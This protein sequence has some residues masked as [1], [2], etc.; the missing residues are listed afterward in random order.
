[1]WPAPADKA[2]ELGDEVW[3][4]AD[5]LLLGA[6]TGLI[7][8]ATSAT[9]RGLAALRQ[10]AGPSQEQLLAAAVAFRRARTLDSGQDL[11]AWLAARELTMEDWEAHLRRSLAA[12]EL[13]RGEYVTAPG[14]FEGE[15][16]ALAVDLACGGWWKRFADLA[17]RLWA[18]T[19]LL[20]DDLALTDVEVVDSE[21]RAEATR[22]MAEFGELASLGE[23]W[24][25]DR[26]RTL[27]TRQRALEE[28]A[29]QCAAA[30]AVEARLAEH[31]SDWTEFCY[32]ELW[33]SSREA[34]N[35]A[36]LC[37]RDDGIAADELAAR[38]G[39]ALEQ[40][41]DRHDSL[42]LSAA[43]LLDGALQDQPFGPV[44]LDG[45]WAVLWLRE[46]RRPSLE[47]EALRAAAA[48]ELL[49]E[50]LDRAGQGQIRDADVL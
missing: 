16:K 21:L 44:T 34:A 13:P 25:T 46:R 11:R 6:A 22:I 28:A 9:R 47:D 10:E 45:G 14:T 42:P 12:R 49:E 40:H 15:D 39:L 41:S 48:A 17:A 43:T 23:S 19:R 32:D 3:T 50:A 2:I 7:E 30:K 4:F 36:L 35:E 24:C 1:M 37:A 20:G 26:L 31:A 33:L 29:R 18:A 27:R 38:A 5:L 8:E